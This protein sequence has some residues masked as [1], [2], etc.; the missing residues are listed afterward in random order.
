MRKSRIAQGIKK[1]T[2]VRRVSTLPSNVAPASSKA[3]QMLAR[4]PA[5]GPLVPTLK[6]MSTATFSV[7][8]ARILR[9]AVSLSRSAWVSVSCLLISTML[10]TVRFGFESIARKLSRNAL[11]FLIL[12]SVS[13][14]E[15][16]SSWR[17][18]LC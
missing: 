18:V 17:S 4:T 5:G 1:M 10:S 2:T 12:A 15:A 9:C 7:S 16:V 14:T 13:T 11:R 3:F 6:E 8:L